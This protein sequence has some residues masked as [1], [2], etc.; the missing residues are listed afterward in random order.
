MEADLIETLS[1]TIPG[2]CKIF[3]KNMEFE[4]DEERVRE[5][6]HSLEILKN[7][8]NKI[9]AQTQEKLKTHAKELR[10]IKNDHDEDWLGKS[11]M[12]AQRG[13]KTQN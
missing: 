10:S 13:K 4:D 11:K 3:Y 12:K 8:I 5:I 9:L 7:S 6:Y 2:L 1:E